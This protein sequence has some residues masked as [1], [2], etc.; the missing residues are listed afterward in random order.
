MRQAV[1]KGKYVSMRELLKEAK[2]TQCNIEF[3]GMGL[4]RIVL[5]TVV[6]NMF[7]LCRPYVTGYSR[8]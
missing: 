4:L 1:E 5:H 2:V 8:H 7:F 3:C 6:V